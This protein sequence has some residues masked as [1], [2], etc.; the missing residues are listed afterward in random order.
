MQSKVEAYDMSPCRDKSPK[1][2]FRPT[3]PQKEA[4]CLMDPVG[5][6]MVH[7]TRPIEREDDKPPV[8]LPKAAIHWCWATAAADPPDEPPG[9]RRCSQGFRVARYAE[10][11]VVLPI[12][13]SSRFVFPSIIAPEA[14]SET[15]MS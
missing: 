11:S 7:G 1:V 14:C 6:D 15:K 12:P 5:K 2:G 9:T 13:N 10:V 4:G 3:T 8:S